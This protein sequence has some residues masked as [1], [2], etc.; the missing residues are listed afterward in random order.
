M[1]PK[2]KHVSLQYNNTTIISFFQNGSHMYRLGLESAAKTEEKDDES[3]K[4]ARRQASGLQRG[5][6]RARAAAHGWHGE[7]R[8]P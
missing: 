8:A 7:R 2:K 1:L 6:C 4:P 3:N 5:R